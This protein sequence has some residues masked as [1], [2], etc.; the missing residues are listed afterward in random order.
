MPEDYNLRARV[1]R[2]QL[3]CHGV[4]DLGRRV[5]ESECSPTVKL[6]REHRL[7]TRLVLEYARRG[8]REEAA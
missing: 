4:S 1:L 7:A 5:M 8:A 2:R 3:L 6:L